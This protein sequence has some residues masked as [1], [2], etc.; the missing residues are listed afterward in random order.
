MSTP[1]LRLVSRSELQHSKSVTGWRRECEWCA[2]PTVNLSHSLP[3]STVG[4]LI[5][6]RAI[7]KVSQ[8][9]NDAVEKGAQIL[10]GGRRINGPGTFFAPTVLS[11]VPPSALVNDEE[12][13]GPIA[14]LIKFETEEEVIKLANNSDVG[15]AGY[16]Y[17]RDIGRVWRV[18]EA[19]EVG[20][21]GANTGT[22]SQAV[23]PFGGIKESGI[24]K[25]TYGLDSKVIVLSHFQVERVVTELK[26]T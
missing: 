3:L 23:V 9:V 11:D 10:I 4:P 8:H 14:P 5:H 16:F 24:G 15:L 22:I 2:N 17:S 25:S 21:V 12:T 19:L 13:F 18:A 6:D 7:E 20:M 26:S 1:N